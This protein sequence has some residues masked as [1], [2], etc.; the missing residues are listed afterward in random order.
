MKFLLE[1]LVCHG[2]EGP[3]ALSKGAWHAFGVWVERVAHL[4][5]TAVDVAARVFEVDLE[6][7]ATATLTVGPRSLSGVCATSSIKR[8]DALGLQ[9]K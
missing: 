7:K 1:F 2:A 5:S 9:R 4:P 8:M 6:E 3:S